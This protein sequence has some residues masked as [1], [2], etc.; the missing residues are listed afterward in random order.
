MEMVTSVLVSFPNKLAPGGPKFDSRC[1]WLLFSPRP[2]Q[3]VPRLAFRGRLRTSWMIDWIL[4]ES[5]RSFP[6]NKRQDVLSHT[7]QMVRVIWE[8]ERI[9]CL[10]PFHGPSVED[11]WWASG[12]IVNLSLKGNWPSMGSNWRSRRDGERERET[13]FAS[14]AH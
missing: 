9:N 13:L 2:K 5:L 14:K 4:S 8:G 12:W 1:K 6:V 10:L 7:V 3:H 11:L